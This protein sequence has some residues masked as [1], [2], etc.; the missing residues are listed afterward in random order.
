MCIR[1]SNLTLTSRIGANCVGTT[2][3]VTVPLSSCNGVSLY[4]SSGDPASDSAA[5]AALC[6]GGRTGTVYLNT[7]SLAT[8]TQV[9][10]EDGCTTLS[11]GP[12]Y[13]SADTSNYYKW[14]GYVLQG[15]YTLNCP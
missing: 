1:D 7:T 9:Y 3:A 10:V 13:L 11:S 6:G 12:R 14:T 5:A 2:H 8:A 4:G 15:P